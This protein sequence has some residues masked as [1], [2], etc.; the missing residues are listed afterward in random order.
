MSEVRPMR[1]HSVY[2]IPCPC[3]ATV[4]A[5]GTTAICVKCERVLEVQVW[6]QPPSAEDAKAAEAARAK[7]SA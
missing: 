7:E 3:G 1:E 4:E 2:V 5:V 6:G